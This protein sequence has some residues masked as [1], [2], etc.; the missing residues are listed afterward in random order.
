MAAVTTSAVPPPWQVVG[1]LGAAV[2]AISFAAIFARLAETPGVV[3]AF[4]R[5]AFASLL[6]VPLSVRAWRRTR[7]T[8]ANVRPALLAGALL[9]LHFATWLS[10]LSYTTVAASVTLVTTTPLWVALI[11][12]ARG[13]R[14]RGGA[15]LGIGL[16]MVGGA[17]IGLGDVRGG[18]DPLLGDLLALVGAM[19]AAGYFLAGRAAQRAGLGLNAYVGVAYGTAAM[20]LAPF[21]WLFGQAYLGWPAD[22]WLWILLM[23]L[24]PQMVGHTGLNYA[25]RHVDPTLVTTVTLLEP[26]GS[27]LLALALFA[28]VPGPLVLLG[29]P[30]LLA[31]L[32][33]VVRYRRR[34]RPP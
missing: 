32:A 31:G 30:V 15:L 8:R 3:M 7:P 33:L 4:W 13:R 34:E 21:P 17:V 20:V 11:S 9:G 23:A 2:I 10:S 16:A 19:A 28:E 18:S 12:W 22:T 29:A 1:V 27:S 5:L 6:L 26:V 25:A 24:A 14:P